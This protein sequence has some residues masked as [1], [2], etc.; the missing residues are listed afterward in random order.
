MISNM[1]PP[2]FTQ[3]AAGVVAR[4]A[5]AAGRSPPGETIQYVACAV[6]EDRGEAHRVAMAMIGEMLPAYWS[7]GERV[8][9][10]KAAM[11][12]AKDLPEAD[13]ASAVERLRAGRAAADVL[14]ARFLA[15]FAIA[16]TPQDCLVQAQR[17]FDAGATELAVSFAAIE[18]QR[19]MKLLG[20]V[21]A[22]L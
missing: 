20:G 5:R 21:M 14:D 22:K 12:R 19:D 17:Y 8:P 10:A 13:I 9:S 11:L 1:C 15:A 3:H 18:P 16:G 4:A 6:R 2:Q 7:L